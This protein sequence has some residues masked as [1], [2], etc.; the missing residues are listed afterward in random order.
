MCQKFML[1]ICLVA[2][3]AGCSMSIATGDASVGGYTYNVHG[4]SGD[5]TGH[6]AEFAILQDGIFVEMEEG[7]LTVNGESYGQIAPGSTIEVDGSR[8]IVNEV[9]LR[10]IG[11][12]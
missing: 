2:S 3:T 12:K 10:A 7:V 8:V 1:A 5:A 9:V 6:A 11:R 4:R